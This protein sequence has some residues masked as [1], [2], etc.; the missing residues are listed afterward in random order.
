MFRRSPRIVSRSVA[1][2]EVF[3]VGNQFHAHEDIVV[4]FSLHVL[5]VVGD[6]YEFPEAY[7]LQRLDG[8]SSFSVH[9]RFQSGEA[10][11]SSDVYYALKENVDQ[12]EAAIVGVCQEVRLS[13]VAFPSSGTEVKGA[14]CGEFAIDE[15]DERDVLN[16]FGIGHPLFENRAVFDA[17]ADEQLFLF[18]ND[19]MKVTEGC[20]VGLLHEADRYR[21]IAVQGFSNGEI[22]E[23]RID[24]DYLVLGAFRMPLALGK[25]AKICVVITSGSGGYR[26][27][28][29]AIRL[30]LR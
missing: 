29:M 12:S 5:D 19:G 18:G 13:D 9:F 26:D 22:F 3:E 14:G 28:S 2:A 21:D 30:G 4:I 27:F 7:G 17:A 8:G 10:A 20:F 24:H 11:L 15:C 1:G 6:P 16:E 23:G 25:E